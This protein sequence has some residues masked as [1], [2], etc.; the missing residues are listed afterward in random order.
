MTQ[1]YFLTCC[2]ESECHNRRKL[3]IHSHKPHLLLQEVRVSKGNIP[4]FYSVKI[5]DP[6]TAKDYSRSESDR[7]SGRVPSASSISKDPKWGQTS[8][9][10]SFHFNLKFKGCVLDCQLREA[11][12]KWSHSVP[13]HCQSGLIR[14]K[15]IVLRQQEP[16]RCSQASRLC[17]SPDHRAFSV[18]HW[19]PSVIEPQCTVLS[20][21]NANYVP[22]AGQVHDK[23]S[24]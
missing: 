1:M 14:M 6:T 16:P 13:G 12:G 22:S 8:L 20:S 19:S 24:E 15:E 11:R 3:P 23:F 4:L 2:G 7:S 18:L 10:G 17:V 21:N 9:T 5:F